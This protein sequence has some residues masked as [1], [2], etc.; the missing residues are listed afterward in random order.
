MNSRVP[1]DQG[2][3]SGLEFESEGLWRLARQ[4]REMPD[5]DPPGNLLP[6]VMGTIRRMRFPWW[7][8]LLRWTRSPRSLTFT[9]LQAASLVSVLALIAFVSALQVMR[10]EPRSIIPDKVTGGVPVTFTLNMPEARSVAVVGT[11]NAWHQKGYEM[12]RDPAKNAWTLLL[13]LPDGRYE[14]AFVLDGKNLVP[15]P[16]A[17]LF[18]EDGFGNK[19]A[20]LIVGK[21]HDEAI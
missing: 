20:V 17:E 5:L 11:F 4:V 14:Y 8:R 7:Y 1:F 2:G 10:S 19:N 3:P 6:S 16:E 13:R 21:P 12:T 15:D 18:A 9:P